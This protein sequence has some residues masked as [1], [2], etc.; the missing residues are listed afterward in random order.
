MGGVVAVYNNLRRASG[1]GM[2]HKRDRRHHPEGYG[3]VGIAL[4]L[5]VSPSAAVGIAVKDVRASPDIID[6]YADMTY[7]PPPLVPSLY[8]CSK[9]SFL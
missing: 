6:G 1:H 5:A 3:G 4:D 9:L 2:G 7:A 8:L